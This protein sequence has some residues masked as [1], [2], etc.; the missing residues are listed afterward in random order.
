[1]NGCHSARRS[2]RTRSSVDAVAPSM[3]SAVHVTA[4][5]VGAD[6]RHLGSGRGLAPGRRRPAHRPLGRRRRLAARAAWRTGSCWPTCPSPTWC[7]GCRWPRR[8]GFVAVAQMRPTTGPTA[9][10]DDV[11]GTEVPRGRRPQ[12]DQAFDEQRICRERDPDW[13]GD[14]PVREETIPVVRAGRVVG[15]RQPAHQPGR[16]AHPE[17]ARADLPAHGRR[18]GPDG[19]P[20]PLPGRRRRAPGWRTPRGSGTG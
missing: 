11:V 9:H 13:P 15:R 17:P 6:P 20:G 8:A 16:G 7:C 19:G 10:H 2:R 5:T 12:L 1:M 18:P 14:V 4:G 3:P